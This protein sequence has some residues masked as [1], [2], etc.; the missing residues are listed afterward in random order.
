[1]GAK[2]AR[3]HDDGKNDPDNPIVPFRMSDRQM[4]ALMELKVNMI[5]ALTFLLAGFIGAG[6]A[7]KFW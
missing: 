5:V 4:L 7:L 2:E 1:M 3:Q 6:M